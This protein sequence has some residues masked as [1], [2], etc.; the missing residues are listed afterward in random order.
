MWRGVKVEQKSKVI[1]H[2]NSFWYSQGI[3]PIKFLWNSTI[4]QNAISENI[5]PMIVESN[6]NAKFLKIL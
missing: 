3:D 1:Y 6:P 2:T 4:Y 5:I